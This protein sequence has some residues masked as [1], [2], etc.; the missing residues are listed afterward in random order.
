MISFY[1]FRD[2]SDAVGAH[3]GNLVNMS[4]IKVEKN[5]AHKPYVKCV[6]RLWNK[7]DCLT[8]VILIMQT[9]VARGKNAFI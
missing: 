6:F 9:E 7:D 5:W 3:N 2:S 4:K 8:V 1:T